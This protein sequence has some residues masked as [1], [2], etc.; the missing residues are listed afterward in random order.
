MKGIGLIV[1]GLVIG[2]VVAISFNQNF[3]SGQQRLAP[4]RGGSEDSP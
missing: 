4:V 1:F 2:L 3:G